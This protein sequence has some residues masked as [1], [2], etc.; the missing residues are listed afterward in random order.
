MRYL[1]VLRFKFLRLRVLSNLL[2]S[3]IAFPLNGVGVIGVI[4]VKGVEAPNAP[5]ANTA[6]APAPANLK[7]P[8]VLLAD[9]Y[10]EG[11]E[12]NKRLPS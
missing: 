10:G 8:P 9:L 4:G 12:G 6:A 7:S 1:R 3:H 5:L 2:C 11:L